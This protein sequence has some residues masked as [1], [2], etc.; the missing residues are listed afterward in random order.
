MPCRFFT[1]HASTPQ[2]K[3]AS[4]PPPLRYIGWQAAVRCANRH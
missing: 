2:P 4:A 1:R 3:P